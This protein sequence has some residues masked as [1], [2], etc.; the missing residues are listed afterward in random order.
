MNS[1]VRWI[2]ENCVWLLDKQINCHIMDTVTYIF[3]VLFMKKLSEKNVL[4]YKKYTEVNENPQ[5]FHRNRIY[6]SWAVLEQRKHHS[7]LCMMIILGNNAKLIKYMIWFKAILSTCACLCSA[8]IYEVEM[9]DC[10]FIWMYIF[11]D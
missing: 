8:Y 10:I 6:T 5:R 1:V 7:N 3:F 4:L 9:T 2:V 11:K